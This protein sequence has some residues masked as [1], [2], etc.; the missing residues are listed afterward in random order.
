MKQKQNSGWIATHTDRSIYHDIIE[1]ARFM[2]R[3]PTQ[4][5]AI[6]WS[7]LRRNQLKG[8]QFRRQHLIGRFIVDFHCSAARLIIEVDGPIHDEIE[9]QAYDEARQ[10]FLEELGFTV[11]R[12]S[13]ET[14]IYETEAVLEVIAEHLPTNT[15]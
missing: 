7:R 4:A 6:L 11:L 14:A 15:D 2:R 1:R 9:Q 5:E 12:F 13:N 8:C 10:T 3:N